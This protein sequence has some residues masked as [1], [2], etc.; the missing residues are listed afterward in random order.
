[1]KTPIKTL[2]AAA[3]LSST[4]ASA[5]AQAAS[6]APLTRT[7][8]I[9]VESE[10]CGLENLYSPYVSTTCDHGGAW[11]VVYVLEVGYGRGGKATM[12]GDELP[13]S[14]LLMSQPL[15][16]INRQL[17]SCPTGLP[18]E[19]YLY[20]YNLSGYQSGRFTYENTSA[21]H[22]FNNFYRWIIIW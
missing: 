8:I 9:A 5:P 3:M 19:G 16:T 15:C 10:N 11:L 22:P 21:T 12:V 13:R 17:T 18:V 20:A 7:D 1:M 4:I 2:L 6:A 14:A